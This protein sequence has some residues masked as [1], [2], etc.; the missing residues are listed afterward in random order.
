[1]KTSF[2]RLCFFQRLARALDYE[3]VY[4]VK[5]TNFLTEWRGA[6]LLFGEKRVNNETGWGGESS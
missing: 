2:R 6:L 4:G 1:M 5:A 3:T